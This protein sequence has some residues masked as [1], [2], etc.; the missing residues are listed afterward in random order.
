VGTRYLK[1]ID[2]VGAKIADVAFDFR[3]S[4]P[5][6]DGK[7]GLWPEKLNRLVPGRGGRG[8]G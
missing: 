8:R 6:P 2:V 7:P 5:G 4:R 1:R 3:K